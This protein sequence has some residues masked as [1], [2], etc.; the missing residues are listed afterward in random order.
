MKEDK[1]GDTIIILIILLILF[2]L[3]TRGLFTF[4][5]DWFNS[6]INIEDIMKFTW[7]IDYKWFLRSTNDDSGFLSKRNDDTFLSDSFN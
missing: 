4:N 6:S 5:Y 1:T 7:D 3:F 2:L